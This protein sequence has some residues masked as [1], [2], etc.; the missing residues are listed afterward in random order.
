MVLNENFVISEFEMQATDEYFNDT[1][2]EI[3]FHMAFHIIM[4]WFIIVEFFIKIVCKS[5]CLY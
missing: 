3:V 2:F 5:V 1:L 4:I